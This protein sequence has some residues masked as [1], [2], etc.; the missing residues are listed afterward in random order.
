MTYPQILEAP[1]NTRNAVSTMTFLWCVPWPLASW[2]LKK[3]AQT[4]NKSQQNTGFDWGSNLRSLSNCMT[5][6]IPLPTP[7]WQNGAPRTAF[8][9]TGA[10]LCSARADRCPTPSLESGTEGVLPKLDQ[11][12]S[13]LLS[14]NVTWCG[15]FWEHLSQRGNFTFRHY[16]VRLSNLL[17]WHQRGGSKA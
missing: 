10:V 4:G 16:S 8:P 2:L 5:L 11:F 13:P 9:S 12:S 17:H 3:G 15:F 6:R 7:N 14:E 1:S